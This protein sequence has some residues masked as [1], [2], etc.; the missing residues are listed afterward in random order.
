MK[1]RLATDCV[2]NFKIETATGFEHSGQILSDYLGNITGGDFSSGEGT[3]K[4]GQGD[5]GQ[6]GFEIIPTH[7]SLEIRATDG[8]AAAYAVFDLLEKY[9]GCRFYSSDYEVVPRD[10]NLTLELEHYAFKPIMGYREVYYRDY[11]DSLFAE[12]NKMAGNPN[13][14]KGEAHQNWGFWCH[15]FG[16]LLPRTLFDEHPE[17]FGEIDGV[18]SRDNQP[19]LSNPAVLEIMREN[20]ASHI[21]EKPDALYW[22]VSQDDNANYCRCEKCAALDEKEGGPMGSIL[23]FVNKIAGYFPEKIIS[24]LA[25]WYSRKPPKTVRPASNVHIMLCNIEANR[26]QPIETDERSRGSRDELLEW[27]KICGNVF[28]WDYC[29]QFANLVSPFPNLHVLAP[30]IRFFVQN[31]VRALFSQCNREIG[32]EFCELRGYMLAKLMWDPNIDE[33]EVMDDFLRGYYGKAAPHIAEYIKLI[34]NSLE[35]S[36]GRLGIFD[37]PMSA[38]ESYLTPELTAVYFDIFERAVEAVREEDEIIRRH[39]LTAYLP[40]RYAAIRDEY[41]DREFRLDQIAAFAEGT[42]AAGMVL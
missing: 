3:I 11:F 9:A 18:R 10:P 37:S 19:C 21:A 23:T 2:A 17:Y 41:G 36:G 14:D 8:Q 33:N 16:T 38:K 34:H 5:C 42:K 6:D 4:I 24:T 30:N 29:I 20:L 40:L 1:I 39:V 25:Y 12:K 35:E 13:R 28:L 32:G 7:R 26:G 31:N 22:S 27:A 15:S